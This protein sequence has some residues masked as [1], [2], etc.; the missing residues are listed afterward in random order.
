[1]WTGECEDS[2]LTR[3]VPRGQHWGGK[4]RK[5]TS[6]NVAYDSKGDSEKIHALGGRSP[7]KK[8]KEQTNHCRATINIPPLPVRHRKKKNE[9]EPRSKESGQSR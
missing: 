9:I 8:E 2:S 1:M 3:K 5:Q 7:E 4:V 6:T